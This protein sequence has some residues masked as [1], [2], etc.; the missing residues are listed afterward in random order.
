MRKDYGVAVDESTALYYD[1]GKAKTYGKNGVFITDITK[2]TLNTRVY[3]AISNVIVH[4]LT[5]G[6]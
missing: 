3:F 6:D 1:N 5:S 2:A 4:Y